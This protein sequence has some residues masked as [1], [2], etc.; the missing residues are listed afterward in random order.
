LSL[1]DLDLFGLAVFGEVLMGLVFV[2][3]LAI[4]IQGKGNIVGG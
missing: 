3:I 1:R 4:P 2:L